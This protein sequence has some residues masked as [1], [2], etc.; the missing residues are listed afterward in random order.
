QIREIYQLRGATQEIFVTLQGARMAA[1]RE[2]NRQRF[3]LVGNTYVVHN[4]LNCN[5]VE[6][7]G[8]PKIQ[9]NIQWNARGVSLSGMSAAS[10]LTF[11]QNGTAIVSGGVSAITVTNASGDQKMILVSPGGR[12]RIN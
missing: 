4:D 1:V 8:E 6:D 5:G 2:N 11:L 3:Y 9:K 10:A 12:I 7:T